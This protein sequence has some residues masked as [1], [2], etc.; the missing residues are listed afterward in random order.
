M[1][2]E[3]AYNYI[4][5]LS[6]IPRREFMA[7]PKQC[8]LYIKRLQFFL[9][10]IGNPEKKIPHYIHITGTSGKGST[11][12]FLHEILHR[13][14]KKVAS[15][16]S[17][18]PSTITQR[19]RV[20]NRF[21]S[22]EEFVSL[23]ETC[24]P[25]LDEYARENK[26][27]LLSFF[28]L[29]EALAFHWFAEQK[30]EWA[31]LEVGCGGR[32]DSTNV[33]PHKDVAVITNIG[34]DHVGLIGSNKKEIAEEK[35]GIIRGDC[36]VF[37]AEQNPDITNIIEE[38]ATRPIHII[39]PT[40]ISQVELSVKGTSFS[41]QGK[42]YSTQA[43]GKHQ[44]LNASL[45]I[46]VASHIGISQ[47]HIK[48]GIASAKQPLRLEVIETN[49]LLI[50]D[51]AHNEDKI[52]STVEGLL[53]LKKQNAY[54]NI[55]LVIGFS[56]SKNIAQLCELLKQL[57]PTSVSCTRNTQNHFRKVAYPPNIA[58][59]FEDHHTS[60]SLDPETALQWPRSQAEPEDLILVTGSVFLGGEIRGL[61]Y[62]N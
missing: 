59:L 51:G 19:W 29:T 36:V 22:K 62:T 50:V 13:A 46:D 24:K 27:E 37:T 21:M 8:G 4:L 30:V 5:S 10:L 12:N 3:Q 39:D 47:Y 52:A 15:T 20:G 60:I 55:H 34:L 28:E 43:I 40:S 45:A 42:S 33:I 32:F 57:S 11:T 9:D 14:G 7:D 56:E 44:A 6:N 35:S 2:F 49:P 31:V 16:T 23:V 26:Y 53:T 18:Y 1:T 58:A 17:P 25:K 54:N 41:Y 48:K 38:K 61:W